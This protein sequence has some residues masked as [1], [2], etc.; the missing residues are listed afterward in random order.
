MA[1]SP[2]INIKKDLILSSNHADKDNLNKLKSELN[3]GNNFI[4][5]F[6]ILGLDPKICLKDFIYESNINEINSVY[7]EELSPRILSKFPPFDKSYVNIDENILNYVFENSQI[8][9]QKFN[10]YP[11]NEIFTFL[12]DNY[13]FSLTYP[14][15]YVTCLLFYES[16]YNYKKLQEK[17]LLQENKYNYVNN[18]IKSCQFEINSI[19]NYNSSDATTVSSRTT[20]TN[21]NSNKTLI[22]LKK[23][24][25][26]IYI[27]KV[28]VFV[29]VQPFFKEHEKILNGILKYSKIENLNIPLEKIILNI[30]EEIPIPPRGLYQVTYQLLN[31]KIELTQNKLNKLINIDYEINIIISL[32]SINNIIEIFKHIL[33]ETKIL[34]FSENFKILFPIIYGFISL[35]TPFKYSFQ[36]A[37]CIPNNTYDILESISPYI[38]GI[39]LKFDKNF[40][41]K[42]YIEIQNPI[43]LVDI[44]TGEIIL[45]NKEEEFPPF[46]K[47]Y[48]KKFKDKLNKTIDYQNEKDVFING[49][50]NDSVRNIF[51]EFLVNLFLDYG[52]YLNINNYTNEEKNISI[53]N[54]FHTKKFINHFS[55][56]DRP[57]YSK[58]IETQIFS[59]FIYRRMLPKDVNEKIEI[60]FFDESIFKK[61][62]RCSFK[63]KKDLKF[64]NSNE[65]NIKNIY[66]VPKARGLLNEDI[67]KFHHKEY[68]LDL[69]YKS[70]EVNHSKG[71]YLFTYTLFPI[72][73]D[74]LFFSSCHDFMIPPHLN[75]ELNIINIDIVSKSHLSSIEMISENMENYIYLIWIQLWATSYWYFDKEERY[76]RFKQMITILDKISHHDLD[77]LNLLFEC[78]NN[79]HEEKMLYELYKKLINYHLN[80]TS[81]IY[82]IMNKIMDKNKL[83]S[84]KNYNN[85]MT[86]INDNQKININKFRKRTLKNKF[87][88]IVIGDKIKFSNNQSCIECGKIIN[89]KEV[90]KNYK[91]M[92]KDY[93]WAKCT[94]C[95]NYILPKIDVQFGMEINNNKIINQNTSTSDNIVLFSPY[96]LKF[97]LNEVLIKE[98]KKKLD[99]ENFRYRFSAI[100]WNCIWYFHLNNLDYSF[101]ISYDEKYDKNIKY[102]KIIN[103]LLNNHIV[104]FNVKNS[105]LNII[106][107][108]KNKK[109][110][111]KQFKANKLQINNNVNEFEFL[112]QYN[113]MY[114]SI[115]SYSLRRDSTYINPS[116]FKDNS[117]NL[118][119]CSMNSDLPYNYENPFI[120]QRN[121]KLIEIKEDFDENIKSN[122]NDNETITFSSTNLNYGYH[123]FKKKKSSQF[124]KRRTLTSKN[125]SIFLDDI[126]NKEIIKKKK[127][128]KENEFDLNNFSNNY[129]FSSLNHSFESD[130][131]ILKEDPII[132]KNY[133]LKNITNINKRKS[134]SLNKIRN[135]KRNEKFSLNNDLLDPIKKDNDKKIINC[136]KKKSED[137][138]IIDKNIIF[139]SESGK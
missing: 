11:K 130:D 33:F 28:I 100:F 48:F 29:S 60:L 74:D 43:L 87:E 3:K 12:L 62:N 53:Y 17:I 42:N 77:V 69:L 18:R 133:K 37:S 61:N 25:E 138:G 22:H 41:E 95:G 68:M 65:Y 59:D 92:K 44:D 123:I 46:P 38:L 131:D 86:N 94:N 110:N 105:N 56:Y 32:F 67:E 83:K 96:N 93:L 63:K 20:F 16:L 7:K 98:M 126:N 127:T 50:K 66:S 119:T 19:S 21:Y 102:E 136:N 113:N 85:I 114:V 35:I 129:F 118:D 8:K 111:K 15:K 97:S 75:D 104:S 72:L 128:K 10:K 101:F 135:Y 1:S 78:L 84:E 6:L 36:I 71:K 116:D 49:D 23:K 2:K 139:I 5:Y 45:K 134:N 124:K 120:S 108:Q 13:F 137:F 81:F 80:P 57:F 4:D 132:N 34:F 55:E 26:H 14:H 31:E 58:I 73:N 30:L 107:K 115:K 103:K 76:Y 51:Y 40:L 106:K 24:L 89:L 91:N 64:L 52:D 39:N 117:F 125:N 82:S 47:H 122:L 9:L 88:N 99:V 27:P 79:S 90:C 109:Q 70:Q 54:L 121:S 112:H